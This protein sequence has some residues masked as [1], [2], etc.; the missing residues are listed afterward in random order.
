VKYNETVRVIEIKG[1]NKY[2]NNYIIDN[3]PVIL[4]NDLNL[5]YKRCTMN[6]VQDFLR[7]IM[8]NNAYNPVLELIEINKWDGTD[9]LPELYRIMRI[10]NSDSLILQ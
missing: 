1:L 10:D 4:Y 2:N 9:R 8:M 5:I 7:I 6:A 3:F